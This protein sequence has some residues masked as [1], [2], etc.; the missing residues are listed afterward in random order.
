[1]RAEPGA[2]EVVGEAF[3]DLRD[4]QSAGVGGDDGAGLADGV[5]FLEEGAFKVEVFDDGF[6]DPVDF[7]ELGG[8]LPLAPSSDLVVGWRILPQAPI[9]RR[10]GSALWNRF[11]RAAFDLPVR[12]VEAADDTTRAI[13][14]FLA[15]GLADLALP[16][17]GA[18]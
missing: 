18:E 14:G 17:G 10:V 2:A 16:T 6:D 8:F 12:D 3:G 1:M 5:D 13:V 11:L 4:G 9:G 15:E 7:G